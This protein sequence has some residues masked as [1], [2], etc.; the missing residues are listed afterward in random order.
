MQ[1]DVVTQRST[2][3]R[4]AFTLVELLVV[5]G[6]IALLISILIP[7][8]SKARRAAATAAAL[9]GLRQ[10]T[11]DYIQYANQ[12]NGTLLPGF[13]AKTYANGTELNVYDV[14]SKQLLTGRAAQQWPWRLSSIDPGMWKIIRPISM[15]DLP[16]S[17][18]D[19]AT[20][21]SKAYSASLYPHFGLNT[22]FLGGHSA[23]NLIDN[24]TPKDFYCG[25]LQSG[26]PNVGKHVAFKMS[27]IRRSAEQI[28]FCEVAIKNGSQSVEDIDLRGFHYVNPPRADAAS[29]TYWTVREHRAEVVL[30]NATRAVGVPYSRADKK[31]PVSFLDGHAEARPIEDLTDMRNWSPKATS[32]DWSF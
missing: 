22:I 4:A 21:V 27:E 30:A 16:L 5:I 29:G 14:R 20:A 17:D 32:P 3:K 12:N 31:I 28:V 23:T 24:E 18:D 6:I 9:S 19:S 13:L 10:I 8:L 2:L 15:N 26:R 1:N 7:T 25:Y 11:I